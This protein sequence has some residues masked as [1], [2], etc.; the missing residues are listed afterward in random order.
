MRNITNYALSG[1]ASLY[2]ALAPASAEALSSYSIKNNY[3]QPQIKIDEQDNRFPNV[4]LLNPVPLQRQ[5]IPLELLI[6]L[7]VMPE[8]IVPAP[9]KPSFLPTKLEKMPARSK[10]K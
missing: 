9:H 1:L 8:I 5:P 7:P 2:L 6:G 3:Y 4:V 10:L